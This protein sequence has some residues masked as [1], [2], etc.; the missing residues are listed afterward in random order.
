MAGWKLLRDEAIG[1]VRRLQ[2]ENELEGS[3]HAQ[4]DY[5]GGTTGRLFPNVS[6]AVAAIKGMY[7]VPSSFGAAGI[8]CVGGLPAATIN[9]LTGTTDELLLET[10]D[11]IDLEHST[12][13]EAVVQMETS[14]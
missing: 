10:G 5:W 9:P 2:D 13:N 14:P 6:A 1:S 12:T 8:Y 11:F 4:M 3:V 7:D